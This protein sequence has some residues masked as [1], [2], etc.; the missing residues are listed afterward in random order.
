MNK[1]R[2]WLLVISAKL[3]Y[4]VP[5]FVVA[6]TLPSSIEGQELPS[7]ANVVETVE[8]GIVNISTRGTQSYQADAW[9]GPI[10]N[11]FEGDNF[12]RKYFRFDNRRQVQSVTN[13]GSGVVYDAE[14]GYI[15]TNQ[16]VLENAAQITVTLSDGR[17]ALAEVVGTDPEMDLA[18]LNCRLDKFV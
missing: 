17:E 14:M 7:L 11:L 8:H 10:D 3:L 13:L 9:G 2:N 5:S 6:A 18:L 12:F 16:H 1:K 15:I 4:L